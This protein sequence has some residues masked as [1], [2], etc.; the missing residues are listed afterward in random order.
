MCVCVL[1]LQTHSQ[2][3]VGSA[4]PVSRCAAHR[5]PGARLGAVAGGQHGLCPHPAHVHGETP[6][7]GEGRLRSRRNTLRNNLIVKPP[8]FVCQGDKMK[9]KV[10]PIL[11]LLTESCRAHRE[12]RQ[13]IR[14]HVTFQTNNTV[15]FAVFGFVFVASVVPTFKHKNKPSPDPASSERRVTEAR[16]RH[17]R[18]EPSDPSHDSPG[19]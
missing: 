11:N 17:H 19:H 18:K 10:T 1:L 3:V 13:Y 4:A 2:P 7:V 12:T 16:G 5:V 6:R 15:G 8:G 14:K 9:V